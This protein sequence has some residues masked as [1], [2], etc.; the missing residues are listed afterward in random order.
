M[1]AASQERA[2]TQDFTER[3]Q[4]F[5]PFGAEAQARLARARVLVVG[6]GA[7]GSAMA[8]GLAR[9]GVGALTL[10]DRDLVDAGNLGRQCLYARGDVGRPKA[11]AAAERLAAIVPA[12]AVDAHVAEATP[13][14]LEALAPGAALIV[15]GTDSFATRALINE[16]ACRASIPWIYS[17][18]IG[19]TAVS[20]PIVPG[21]TACLACLYPAPPAPESEERCD[22]LGV[23][24]AAVLQAAALSLTEALKLLGGRTDALR[25]E[26]WTVDLWRGQLGR[27]RAARPRRDCPVCVHGE[28][29]LLDAPRDR[30]RVA[31]L[32]SRT[33]QVT[34]PPGTP[35]P[36]LAAL[37]RRL[38]APAPG[39]DYLRARID[40]LDVVVFP[41][42]RL[43]LVGCD[44]VERALQLHR[45]LLEGA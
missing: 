38:D 26:L 13:T 17:G 22:V 23:L 21:E 42:G 32:C 6:V 16:L 44:S 5:A 20:L 41:D 33:L 2:V 3:Q 39:P 1:L 12:L 36:D 15:D 4:L 25:R 40:G 43:R 7:T 45:R 24:Q 30:P 31:M 35:A 37:A 18:A 8:E 11:R 29:P 28:T 34:P 19:A 14:L 10:V 27:V 9:A